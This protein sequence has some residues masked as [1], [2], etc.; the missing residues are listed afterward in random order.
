MNIPVGSKQAGDRVV[1]AKNAAGGTYSWGETYLAGSNKKTL[2]GGNTPTN[3][4]HTQAGTYTFDATGTNFNLNYQ[5]G[6]PV[7]KGLKSAIKLYCR[8]GSW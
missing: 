4:L 1:Y 8:H 2:V 5:V 3:V 6:D 7:F